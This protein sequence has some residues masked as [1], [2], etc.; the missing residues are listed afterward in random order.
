MFL[1]K[2]WYKNRVPSQFWIEIKTTKS[3]L[4]S[5]CMTPRSS[6]LPPQK[7]PKSSHS[8]SACLWK[9]ST[10][11]SKSYYPTYLKAY[12]ESLASSSPYTC[13]RIL[14]LDPGLLHHQQNPTL[15]IWSDLWLA[16]ASFYQPPLWFAI[17]QLH[18]P[19][20]KIGPPQ[21]SQNSRC[22]RL[23]EPL[24]ASWTFGVPL[25]IRNEEAGILVVRP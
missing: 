7:W 16:P 2:K 20:S 9:M 6:T 15:R 19:Y 21:V 3:F 11:I 14:L 13:R 12:Q 22:N 24:S 18:T 5:H 25:V 1:N 23:P 4:L 8:L 17:L 10:K